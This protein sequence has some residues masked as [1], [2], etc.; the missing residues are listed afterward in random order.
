M[1]LRKHFKEGLWV[2]LFIVN[3]FV[4]VEIGGN[5]FGG[6]FRVHPVLGLE[7][8]L[9]DTYKKLEEGISDGLDLE[10]GKEL[11]MLFFLWECAQ[12]LV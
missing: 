5:F 6:H 10:I 7:N 12:D 8:I 3:E 2:I 4:Y 9:E 11:F 1:K